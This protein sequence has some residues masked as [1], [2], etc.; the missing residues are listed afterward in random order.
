M[1]AK[2]SVVFPAH[3]YGKT[4]LAIGLGTRACQAG[5]RV[6]FAT[7]TKWVAR[8]ADAHSTGRLQPALV[9]LAGVRYRA[10]RC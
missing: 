1:L 3:R 10:L 7:A 8:L 9:R 6:L 4:H 2:K 5:R